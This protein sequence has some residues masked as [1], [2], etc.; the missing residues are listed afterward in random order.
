MFKD[1]TSLLQKSPPLPSN[2]PIPLPIPHGKPLHLP[3][4]FL[5]TIR[6]C[7][8]IMVPQIRL[9]YLSASRI[10]LTAFAPYVPCVSEIR[11]DLQ[12]WG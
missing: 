12:V 3:Q 11:Q 7:F 4:H 1:P 9:G 6:R 2:I 5:H 10:L 8:R